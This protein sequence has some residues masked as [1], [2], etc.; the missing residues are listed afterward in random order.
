MSHTFFE[1]LKLASQ[2]LEFSD[3]STAAWHLR[4]ALISVEPGATG[5]E[6]ATP[7]PWSD[8]AWSEA[9]KA[10][11]ALDASD[12]K[13]AS[14]CLGKAIDQAAPSNLIQGYAVR[15]GRNLARALSRE[16]LGQVAHHLRETS[17]FLDL[18][19]QVSLAGQA[20]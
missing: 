7:H 9:R 14:L 8:D 1:Q 3:H 18:Q 4:Q 17:R 2:A 5:Q 19:G 13:L 20:L 6:E 11:E 15:H 16:N 12:F 10:V